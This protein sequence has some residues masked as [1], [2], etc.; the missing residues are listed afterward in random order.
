MSPSLFRGVSVTGL[1]LQC[2]K[3]FEPDPAHTGEGTEPTS[4][5]PAQRVCLT[6]GVPVPS[7]WKVRIDMIAG[8]PAFSHISGHSSVAARVRAF[9]HVGLMRLSVLAGLFALWEGLGRIFKPA[10][11]IL[12]LPSRIFQAGWAQ[13]DYLLHHTFITFA[14]IIVALLVGICLGMATALSMTALPW[15][16]RVAEP[17]LIASQS[18]PVFAIAPLL[19]IWFGYGMASKIVMATLII[20]FPVAT[21]FYDGLQRT[22][23]ALLDLARLHKATRWQ[24]L[25]FIRFPAALPG[26]ASGLRVAGAIAPIGA[27]VGEWVGASGGLGYIMLQANARMQTDLV[28]AALFMLALAALVL[29]SLIERFISRTIWWTG[30][31]AHVL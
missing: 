20:Y 18:L 10:H 29:R 21:A 3:P 12:P 16:K 14:E 27:V 28:F 11:F 8:R 24:V 17:V 15:V 19:V 30:E 23:G 25:R 22:P 4:Q 9:L 7:I 13:I 26:L 2:A 5:N 6:H 31:S 1:R